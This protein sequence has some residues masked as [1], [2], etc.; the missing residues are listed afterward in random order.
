MGWLFYAI[1]APV[2]LTGVNFLDKY[3]LEREIKNYLGMPIISAIVAGIFGSL[4]WVGLGFPGLPAWDAA[5]VVFTGVISVWSFVLYFKAIAGEE[6]STVI[7]LLQLQPI[8]ALI[9]AYIL[10]QE[11]ITLRQFAGFW[12][13]LLPAVGL[14]L[15]R[16]SFHLSIYFWLILAG[17]SVWALSEVLFKLIS[18][19][20]PF[21]TLVVYESWGI[22]I[23]GIFL[24][25]VPSIRRAFFENLHHMRFTAFGLVF[26]NELVFVGSKLCKL[27]AVTLGPI[28]LVNVLSSTQ[29][30]FAIALDWALTLLLPTVFKADFSRANFL[31][32]IAGAAVM[33]TG[34]LLVSPA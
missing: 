2:M 6:T 18:E 13:I 31:R 7:V 1:L 27:L 26:L 19:D 32:K 8:V 14:S 23:G 30:F 29:I 17:V 20:H 34:L 3:I 12:L 22:G 10:L 11:V 21:G 24:Y 15:K 33:F 28:A 25:L 4:V 9:L 16:G 5:V